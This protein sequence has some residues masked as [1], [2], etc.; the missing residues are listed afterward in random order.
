MQFLRD[1][2]VKCIFGPGTQI[3]KAAVDVIDAIETALTEQG[4]D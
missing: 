3:T 2:G 1:A 4:R